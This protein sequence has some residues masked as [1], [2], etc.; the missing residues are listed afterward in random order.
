MS[1]EV[2]LLRNIVIFL[3]NKSESVDMFLDYKILYYFYYLF[4]KN[5]FVYNKNLLLSLLFF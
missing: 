1:V 3:N 4:V 5:F 2:I